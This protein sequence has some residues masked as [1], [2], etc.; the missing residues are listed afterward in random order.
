[1]Q[2]E[3]HSS[4]GVDFVNLLQ[5]HEGG[6]RIEIRSS[7][8]VREI[9]I[10]YRQHAAHVPEARFRPA[11]DARFVN[12]APRPWRIGPRKHRLT[13]QSCTHGIQ[14]YH[15]KLMGMLITPLENL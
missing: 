11:Q 4:Q 5:M 14:R 13:R 6:S 12:S 10:D 2:G 8:H 15:Q 1:M 9:R 3:V 7:L